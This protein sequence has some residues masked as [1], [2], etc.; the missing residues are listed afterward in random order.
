MSKTYGY[1]RVS[2]KSQHIDRQIDNI[3]TSYPNAIIMKESYTGTKIDGRQI[4]NKLLKQVKQGDTIVFDSVSRMSRNSEQGF[5]LYEKL[6]RDGINLVFLKEPHINTDTYKSTIQK[7]IELQGNEVDVILEAINKY[8]MLLAK[9]Q[10]QIAFDQSE[11][12]VKDLQQRTREGIEK[13]RQKGKQIGRKSGIKLITKK[14]IEAKEKIKKYNN[15]FNGSLTNEET[16]NLIGISKMTFYKYK[17][18]ILEEM[19]AEA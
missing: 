12:E 3:K 2:T 15:S 7:Q 11:K 14:S 4:F 10:I 16:W 5:Q 19:E 8:L 18:E 17:N 13:A 1:C 6:Y 9:K